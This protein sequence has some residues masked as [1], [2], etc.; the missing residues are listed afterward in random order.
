[1]VVEDKLASSHWLDEKQSG[2]VPQIVG[3]A[4]LQT[5]NVV[6]TKGQ[7]GHHWSR[8]V[9]L[10]IRRPKRKMYSGRPHRKETLRVRREVA[11]RNLSKSGHVR[12]MIALPALTK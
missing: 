9:S 10:R 3:M 11:R 6:T 1:M 7:G 2:C 5:V 4:R 8:A 12:V